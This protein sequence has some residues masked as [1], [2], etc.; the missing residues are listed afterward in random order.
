MAPD[1]P[2]GCER[3]RPLFSYRLTTITTH[4]Y[5]S[6]HRS[7]L[8]LSLSIFSH[9]TEGFLASMK[10]F[11]IIKSYDLI[12]GVLTYCCSNQ[13]I[14]SEV[15]CFEIDLTFFKFE[16]VTAPLIFLSQLTI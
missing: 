15:Y 13:G 3:K 9:F 16:I 14:N 2:E 4:C 8:K 10:Y 1:N 6:C 7:W 11:V 5:Q 12:I